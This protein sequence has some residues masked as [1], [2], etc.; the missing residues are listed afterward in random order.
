M[1]RAPGSNRKDHQ[2]VAVRSHLLMKI[3]H[4]L[5]VLLIGLACIGCKKQFHVVIVNRYATEAVL[6]EEEG[7]V[8]RV[9]PNG[10]GVL[11]RDLRAGQK[12]A[13][14]L[15]GGRR[16]THTVN[17]IKKRMGEGKEAYII[18]LDPASKAGAGDDRY[19]AFVT[20]F[21]K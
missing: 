2:P 17:D 7:P 4:L 16:L 6:V 20:D 3:K 12:F 11:L 14:E 8:L 9:P 18:D 13:F 10:T 5:V 21:V 1:V 15:A 19:P